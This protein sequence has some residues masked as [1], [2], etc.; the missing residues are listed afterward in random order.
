M[1]TTPLALPAGA[2]PV[3][4]RPLCGVAMISHAGTEHVH[5]GSARTVGPRGGQAGL[6]A[7]SRRHDLVHC[8]PLPPRA[9]NCWLLVG[10]VVTVCGSRAGLLVAGPLPALCALRRSGCDVAFGRGAVLCADHAYADS[11]GVAVRVLC[12][13]GLF[14]PRDYGD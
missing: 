7:V 2:P 14:S 6:S 13:R 4:G 3:A 8:T 1:L 5:V 10:A 11:R 12:V 9:V